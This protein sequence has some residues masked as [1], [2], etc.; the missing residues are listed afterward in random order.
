MRVSTKS[1]EDNI[2]KGYA[3]FLDLQKQIG[4]NVKTLE[5]LKKDEL[6]LSMGVAK[7]LIGDDQKTQ[8]KAI[9]EEL[10]LLELR[11]KTAIATLE[12]NEMTKTKFAKE[13]FNKLS[14][15][16]DDQLKFQNE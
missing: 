1:L 13:A 10:E 4:E 11:V 12:N 2:Q 15:R 14:K 5:K 7:I 8:V 16:V 6:E 3:K 9:D